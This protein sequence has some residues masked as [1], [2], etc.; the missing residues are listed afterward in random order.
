MNAIERLKEAAEKATPGPWFDYSPSPLSRTRIAPE[1]RRHGERCA[2]VAWLGFDDSVRSLKE[3]KANAR[4]IATANPTT[5]IDMCDALLLAERAFVARHSCHDDNDSE[6]A[7]PE[8]PCDR[9]AQEDLFL[10][11]IA[12]FKE[13]S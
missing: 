1:V 3:H 12:K 10:D 13:G 4:H 11:A 7:V 5:I 6:E 8:Y 9:C 2:I